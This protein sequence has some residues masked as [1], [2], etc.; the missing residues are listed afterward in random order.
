MSNHSVVHCLNG[1]LDNWQRMHLDSDCCFELLSCGDICRAF[2]CSSTADLYHSL[3][4]Q[5]A[6]YP[7][8]DALLILVVLQNKNSSFMKLD[9]IRPNYPRLL[10]KWRGTALEFNFFLELHEEIQQRDRV[11]SVKAH[12]LDATL[13]LFQKKPAYWN[14]SLWQLNIVKNIIKS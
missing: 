6:F 10:G 9:R 4:S 7:E 8:V 12:P 5:P 2:F 3:S 1:T 14:L 11:R 13:K